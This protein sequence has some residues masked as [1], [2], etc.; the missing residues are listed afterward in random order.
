VA[1]VIWVWIGLGVLLSIPALIVLM[2]AV[3]YV[4][5]RHKYM[6]KILRVFQERPLF[7]IP[8]GQPDPRAEEVHFPNLEGLTLRGCYFRTPAARQ[9]VIVFGLEFGSN[10]WSCTPYCESLVSNGFDV[11]A[12]E[13]R[14][15]GHSDHQPQYEPMQWV[16]DFEVKDFQAAL[17]YLK[18]RPDADTRG[19]GFFGISKGGG[20]G[21][22]A[23]A[24]DPYVRC[25]VTDGVF[26]TYTTMVPYM[27]KWVRIYNDRYWMQWLLPAW[28][29]GLV[30]RSGLR[31]I[32]RE[33]GCRFP[34]LERAIAKLSP[35]PLLMIHGGGDTYIKP[36]MARALYE[37]A[38]QP[39]DFW[40]VEGAKHNQALQV[41]GDDYHG[42]VLSFFLTH[43]AK[44]GE[45]VDESHPAKAG[46]NGNVKTAAGARQ[47]ADPGTHFA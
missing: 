40:L 47:L 4:H 22:L 46:L 37:R 24:R 15:Q 30:G 14:N 9:G 21:L 25:F 20:A 27:Q 29:Y 23:A 18:N 17:F 12:F 41:A 33:R 34:H 2:F 43:L 31:R 36:E 7:I 44:Q 45:R 16:T 42:R 19:V 10:C 6:E 11:L 35:R 1:T 13:P 28:F 39:K 8:R 26:A 38:G 3:L 32:S 5:L